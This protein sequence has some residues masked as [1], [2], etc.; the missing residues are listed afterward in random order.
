MTE[1]LAAAGV[2]LGL[3]PASAMRLAV[4]T[5]YG[6]GTMAMNSNESIELLRQRVT[7]PGGTTQAALETLENGQFN[8]LMFD[9][10]QAATI[11]GSELARD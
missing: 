5:S 11:R 8:Q 6:A 4:H 7:S 9:A 1:A 2:K 3:S 10:V